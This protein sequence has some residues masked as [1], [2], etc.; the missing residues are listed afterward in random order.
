M[1]AVPKLCEVKGRVH[2][3]TIPASEWTPLNYKAISTWSW[4]YGVSR[5][6]VWR[7]IKSGNTSNRTFPIV[8]VVPHLLSHE[9]LHGDIE[10]LRQI[11]VERELNG[12]RL[13]YIRAYFLKRN[14]HKPEAETSDSDDEFCEVPPAPPAPPH[15]AGTT[16][17]TLAR[18]YDTR[19]RACFALHLLVM[20]QNEDAEACHDARSQSCDAGVRA[21]L[22]RL[23]M[24]IL[25]NFISELQHVRR[26]WERELL[27]PSAAALAEEQV[28]S[29]DDKVNTLLFHIC[30]WQRRYPLKM[31]LSVLS[32]HSEHRDVFLPASPAD[33][34]E[35]YRVEQLLEELHRLQCPD[36]SDV[37]GLIRC[38]VLMTF[39]NMPQD[40]QV[41][42]MRRV[43]AACQRHAVTA[44][45]AEESEGPRLQ[46]DLHLH[47]RGPPDPRVLLEGWVPTGVTVPPRFC[48]GMTRDV[49]REM[50]AAFERHKQDGV[51][52]L[53]VG[54]YQVVGEGGTIPPPRADGTW[55][56]SAEAA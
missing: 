4:K 36:I 7:Q 43:T 33:P 13:S 44:P 34:C 20:I 48:S 11:A 47:S 32:F 35:P 19:S 41:E 49:Y 56:P 46:D 31:L 15:H 54:D 42:L 12:K 38:D 16:N 55:E 23:P 17:D 51:R 28:R 2:Y 39:P 45:S 40:E 22:S 10:R 26:A 37:P 29:D 3:V 50:R 5:N 1:A 24:P 9:E 14:R 52:R 6:A 53:A 30:L 21:M 27:K 18:L 25:H 8:H